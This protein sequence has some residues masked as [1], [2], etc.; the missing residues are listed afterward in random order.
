MLAHEYTEEFLHKL[1]KPQTI[2]MFLSQSDETKATIESLRDDV[3]E[4][5][6]DFKKL[7]ADVSIAKT[8]NNLLMKNA[9]VIEQ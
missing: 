4:M 2:A 9:V 1:R 3:K 7:E 8:V 5:N 6:T